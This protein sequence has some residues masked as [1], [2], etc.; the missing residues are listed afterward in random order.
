MQTMTNTRSVA[1][2][3]FTQSLDFYCERCDAGFWAEPINAVSNVSFLISAAAA[4]RAARRLNA[5]TPIVKSLIV[6]CILVAFGSFAFHTFATRWANLLDIGPIFAFELCVLAW[7]LRRI[8][9][10][11]TI[12]TTL[13]CVTMFVASV[14]LIRFPNVANGSLMYAPTLIAIVGMNGFQLWNDKPGQVWS[15]T[16]LVAMSISLCF[17][18]AD[19]AVC[20][21]VPIGTHFMWHAVNGVVLYAAMRLVMEESS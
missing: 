1:L 19:M 12:T 20:S 14:W 10:L 11:G 6:L 16:L 4:Y 18:T 15:T 2:D 13:G 5:M 17:R 21:V 7:Y 3:W 8:V 9:G